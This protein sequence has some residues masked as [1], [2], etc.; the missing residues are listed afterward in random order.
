MTALAARHFVWHLA[1][2]SCFIFRM[3]PERKSER[4]SNFVRPFN[5]SVMR[6]ASRAYSAAKNCSSAVVRDFMT[7]GGARANGFASQSL[8]AHP[9]AL[10]GT[11]GGGGRVQTSAGTLLPPAAC[12]WLNWSSYR[13]SRSSCLL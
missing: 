8:G 4:N 5:G 6:A 2:L 12:A 7:S 13:S 9:L 3:L 10:Q 1:A 11:A